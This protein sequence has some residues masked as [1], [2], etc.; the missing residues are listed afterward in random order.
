[1]KDISI[2]DAHAT[3]IVIK[4]ISGLVHVLNILLNYIIDHLSLESVT[5]IMS[6]ISNTEP[7]N[8]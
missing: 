5:I 3:L 7:Q 8:L 1:M 4:F 6:F 2:D